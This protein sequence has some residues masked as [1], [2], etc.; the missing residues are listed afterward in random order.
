LRHK[1]MGGMSDGL[2]RKRLQVTFPQLYEMKRNI[3]T[4]IE[5]AFA[6]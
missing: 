5:L 3:Q 6:A 4:K 2:I 1:T